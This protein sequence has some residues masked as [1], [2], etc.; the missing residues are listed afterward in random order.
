MIISPSAVAKKKNLKTFNF[1]TTRF[2]FN[3]FS[4]RLNRQLR[5]EK[6]RDKSGRKVSYQ[7]LQESSF[8]PIKWFIELKREDS[9]IFSIVFFFSRRA[10]VESQ[11]E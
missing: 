9:G 7:I 6:S 4:N 11:S 10:Q 1:P 3:H 8:D 2:S 5:L